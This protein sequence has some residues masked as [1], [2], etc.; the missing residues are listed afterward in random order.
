M[1]H[2]RLGHV[3]RLRELIEKST[4]CVEVTLI[5]IRG[6]APQVLGAR[7]LVT[8]T[9]LECGTVGG[10]KVEA[11]AISKAQQFIREGC[12]EPVI[13]TWNLQTDIGMTCG[14]E[15]KLLFDCHFTRAW[16]IAIFG[17]GHVS[18]SLVRLLMTLDCQIS[19]ID[20]RQEWLDRLPAARNIAVHCTEEPRSMVAT[21]PDDAFFVLMSKGHATDL[22]VLAEVLQ[23][24]QAPYIGVIGSKQKASVL[25]R[26]LKEIGLPDERISQF[27]CPMGLPIGNN[28][29]PEIALSIAAQLLTIRDNHL[30]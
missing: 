17:A 10:G 5:A 16:P 8:S 13:E 4:S 30:R 23:T 6:S 29:P 11:A 9:G 18:Q 2:D 14:G 12:D 22:P 28:T 1:T 20:S 24:R 3:T 26:D 19:V 25:R 21:L 15:V 27:Y 7:A